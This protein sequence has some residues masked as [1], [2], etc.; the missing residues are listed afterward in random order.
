MRQTDDLAPADRRMYATRD[1]TA[2]VEHLGLITASIVSKKLAAGLE[3]LVLDVKCGN[4]A[5]MQDA[6]EARRLAESMV[7]VGNGAGMKTSAL[8]TDMSV[9]LAWSAGNALEV[10]EAVS[11]LKEPAS[12]HP[13]LHEVVMA[14]GSALLVQAG[15]CPDSSAASIAL[16]DT[17]DSGAALSAW[18]SSI[19]AMGGDPKVIE[20]PERVLPQTPVVRPIRAPR[21]G[22]LSGYNVRQVGM[23]WSARWDAQPRGDRSFGGIES[24][25]P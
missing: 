3:H 23:L 7:A 22:V 16:L 8:L 1:V 5:V 25:R 15:V 17:L 24:N 2:T 10:H 18:A 13:R 12:R 14:L 4:G 19:E 20:N 21:S 11:Y 6:E 9:P